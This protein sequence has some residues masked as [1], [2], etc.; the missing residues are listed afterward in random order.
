VLVAGCGSDGSVK[1]SRPAACVADFGNPSAF[2]AGRWPDGCWRPFSDRSPFNTRIAADPR[3]GPQAYVAT[4]LDRGKGGGDV[5]DLPAGTAGTAGDFGKPTFWAQHSDPVYTVKGGSSATGFEVHDQRIRLPAGAKPSAGSDHH[6]T[7]VY[8][9][10]EY[11]FHNARVNPHH[12][13]ISAADETEAFAGRR[14]DLAGVGLCAGGTAARFGNL[15]GIIRAEELEAGHVDHAL[16]IATSVNSSRFVYPAAKS[17]GHR[18]GGEYP[19][20]GTRFQLEPSWATNRRLASFPVWKQ[21]IL[22]ALRD[23]GAYIGDS[24]GTPG[25]T[26]G[27]E[28]GSTY[29]SLGYPDRW[30]EFARR[31]S[32]DGAISP[33]PANADHFWHLDLASGGWQEHLR[34]IAAPRA[35]PRC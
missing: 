17:D 9:G 33:P 11:G 15:A 32:S 12:R 35:A 25:W 18:S 27:R 2:K 14:I 19:P 4:L 5:D 31:H 23:Y 28:S 13:T 29:T 24:R 8:A 16:V 22:R 7:V 1:E 26:I 30:V 3:L 34:V 10:Q 20:M 6:L 21:P